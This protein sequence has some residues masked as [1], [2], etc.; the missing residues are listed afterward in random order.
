VLFMPGDLA[1]YLQRPVTDST[2]IMAERVVTGWLQGAT[3]VA[4]WPEPL[5]AEVF[6]WAIDLA[7]IACENPGG[8][9]SSQTTGSITDQFARERA[10]EILNQAK[11]KYGTAGG[12][13]GK[14]PEP[15]VW[16]DPREVYRVIP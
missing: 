1:D 2:A 7:V 11:G 15:G 4:A 6:S 9:L 10:N 16:H 14:F 3:G 8:L 12:P 5:P 13:R